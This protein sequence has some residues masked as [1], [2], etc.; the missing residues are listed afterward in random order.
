MKPR[1]THLIGGALVLT[2][3]LASAQEFPSKT[4]R[5]IIGFPP[6]GSN[7]VLARNVAPK[8]GELLG[9][10]VVVENRPGANAT[11]ATEYVAKFTPDGHAIMIGSSSPLVISPFTYSKLGYDQ[12]AIL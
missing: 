12:H 10:Q 11:I 1:L 5:L 3:A 4:V 9:Q 6:G 8:L 2:A 7:D